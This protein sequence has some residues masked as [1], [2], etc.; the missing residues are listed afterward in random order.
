M[1]KHQKPNKK[2]TLKRLEPSDKNQEMT[3]C[4]YNK[5]VWTSFR[6]DNK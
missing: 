3:D 1:D 4:D 6:K 2:S 5:D